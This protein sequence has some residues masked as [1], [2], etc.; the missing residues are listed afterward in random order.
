M[1][2]FITRASSAGLYL[3]VTAVTGAL[4]AALGWVQASPSLRAISRS[5][6]SPSRW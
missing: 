3:T 6:R 1:A 5:R 2:P 4:A